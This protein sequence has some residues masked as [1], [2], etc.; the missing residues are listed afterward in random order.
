MRPLLIFF[1][2][3][4]YL[5]L[6]TH[7]ELHKKKWNIY[8]DEESAYFHFEDTPAILH[9]PNGDVKYQFKCKYSKSVMDLIFFILF[10]ISTFSYT[11]TRICHDNA[12]TNLLRHIKHC[13]MAPA[14][15]VPSAS[16]GS[17]YDSA[18]FRYLI[19]K[20]IIRSHRPFSVVS[21]PELKAA[22]FMLNPK[23]E[24]PSRST[25]SRDIQS[26]FSLTKVNVAKRLQ[27]NPGML[28]VGI[29]GWTAPNVFCFLGVTIHF[30]EDGHNQS[31]ILDFIKLTKAHTGQY[32]A[33]KLAQ[34]IQDYGLEKKVF[35][36][37]FFTFFSTT[38]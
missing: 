17:T 16:S 27:N 28:H 5:K 19:L 1:L 38:V 32:L 33:Q 4:F 35:F 23:V 7:T 12:T 34:C 3:C 29:D 18:K 8:N 30:I 25:V 20:W 26:I 6:T 31:L 11:I 2:S 24:V 37:F 15:A 14:R 9:F 10:L 21:D 36:L 22:F 13:T